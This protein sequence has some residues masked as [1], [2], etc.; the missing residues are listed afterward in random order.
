MAKKPKLETPVTLE[1]ER[2]INEVAE[3]VVSQMSPLELGFL[4]YPHAEPVKLKRVPPDVIDDH[5]TRYTKAELKRGQ[6]FR[7]CH[8]YTFFMDHKAKAKR[9]GH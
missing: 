9:E 7:V 4:R 5:L 2:A 6:F 8:R 1:L 3:K